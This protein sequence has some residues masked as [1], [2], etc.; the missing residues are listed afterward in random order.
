MDRVAI[1]QQAGEL[2][3][4]YRYVLLVLAVGVFLMLL[5]ARQEETDTP[6]APEKAVTK[7]ECDLTE[8]LT[9]ILKQVKG[10]GEVKVLLTVA[11]GEK[12]VYQYDSDASA[13]ETG[14]VRH[15]TVI[16]TDG[17]RNQSG[18]VQ[19][20]NPPVYQGAIIVC[21]GAD[22]DV[23]RLHIIEAVARV[24]G[25]GTDKISVLEMK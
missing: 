12:T 20:I 8:E 1:T 14:I 23:V 11:T 9:Q 2:I 21:Q 4:K 5:P 22:N 25:L 7:S 18:L 17:N 19:Q 15:E 3:R 13:G 10:A 6:A 16:V 24:T